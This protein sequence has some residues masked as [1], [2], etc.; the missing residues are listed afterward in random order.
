MSIE[1]REHE[2]SKE[3]IFS[4]SVFLVH[5]QFA[6]AM[7]INTDVPV[8]LP[9]HIMFDPGTETRAEVYKRP[10][11]FP[12]S[13]EGNPIVYQT[14]GLI[15]PKRGRLF[16]SPG[17]G[18]YD[19]ASCGSGFLA[20]L[21]S[22]GETQVHMIES[23]GLIGVGSVSSRA[24]RVKEMRAY[25]TNPDPDGKHAFSY[26]YDSRKGNKEAERGIK[27][28]FIVLGRGRNLRPV[29]TSHELYPYEILYSFRITDQGGVIFT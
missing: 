23:Y 27:E 26:Y 4:E 8:F 7:G 3:Q 10:E 2:S 6:R 1:T 19:T 29:C 15:A 25:C 13:R 18:L 21:E 22:I 20:V 24:A 16:L 11:G 14:G 9:P 5:P 28:G 12:F 17:L